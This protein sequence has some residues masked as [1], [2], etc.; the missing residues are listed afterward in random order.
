[1]SVDLIQKA[2]LVAILSLLRVGPAVAEVCDKVVGEEWRPEHGPVWLL[3]PIGFPIWPVAFLLVMA[4]AVRRRWTK[5]LWLG[6]LSALLVA[7]PAGVSG[8]EG[9]DVRRFAEIE[10]CVSQ[11]TTW[12]NVLLALA[13]ASLLAYFARRSIVER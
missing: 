8:L 13:V 3:A 10:G 11:V 1:M 12:A 6:A 5:V 4:T 2:G 9:D 7:V